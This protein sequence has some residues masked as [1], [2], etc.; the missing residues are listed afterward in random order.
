MNAAS[1]P[2]IPSEHLESV[3]ENALS[4]S[5]TAVGDDH[6]TGTLL[7]NIAVLYQ[8][9]G[10]FGEADTFYKRSLARWER[11]LPKNHTWLA[12]SLSNRASLYR[13]MEVYPE[14]ERVFQ[15]ALAIWRS[16][17]WPSASSWLRQSGYL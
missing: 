10:R 6:R 12:Q 11:A 5:Y 9:L 2:A 17:E 16:T 13:E 4:Q 7:N 8:E 3:L 1:K 14:A 15:Q